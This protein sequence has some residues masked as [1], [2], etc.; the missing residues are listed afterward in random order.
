ML[1]LSNFGKISVNKLLAIARREA[2]AGNWG[3]AATLYQKILA[4]HPKN[5]AAWVQYGH[6]PEGIGRQLRLG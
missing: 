6:A 1:A 5:V 4:D 3:N 2:A